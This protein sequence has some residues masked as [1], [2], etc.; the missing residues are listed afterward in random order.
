MA[1]IW[2]LNSI[3]FNRNHRNKL[4]SKICQGTASPSFGPFGPRNVLRL[5]SDVS[6]GPWMPLRLYN[7]LPPPMLGFEFCFRSI[8]LWT[9]AVIGLRDPSFECLIIY[10]QLSLQLSCV[11]SCSCLCSSIHS[12]DWPSWWGQPDCDTVDNQ[13]RRGARLQGSVFVIWS[14]IGVSLSDQIVVYLEPDGRSG[15]TSP[16][17]MGGCCCSTVG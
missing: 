2:G 12:R 9:V 3:G 11:L 8:C 10:A 13:R 15:I 5:F 6:R 16:L 7:Q 14:R 1:L 4:T 17:A